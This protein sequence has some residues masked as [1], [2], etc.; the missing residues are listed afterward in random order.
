MRLFLLLIVFASVGVINMAHA[1]SP[2][3]TYQPAQNEPTEQ[4]LT[5]LIHYPDDIVD[6]IFQAS[7]YPEQVA[8][9]A[10]YLSEPSDLAGE[11]K[12][13][14]QV[15]ALMQ[16][17]T[18]LL[19]ISSDLVW[20][21]NLG[22]AVA[23]DEE[24]IWLNLAEQRQVLLASA[25]TITVERRD[26]HIVYRS[27]PKIRH[28]HRSLSRSWPHSSS[29]RTY[30]Y[31][32][33]PTYSAYWNRRAHRQKHWHNGHHH[34]PLRAHRQAH[35]R[36][37]WR[38]SFNPYSRNHHLFQPFGHNSHH[39][40]GYINNHRN[41]HRQRGRHHDAFVY[42]N[43]RQVKRQITR[44]RNKNHHPGQR[45]EGSK[46][47]NRQER[48]AG[49]QPSRSRSA[50]GAKPTAPSANR[51]RHNADRPNRDRPHRDRPH[52]DRPYMSGGLLLP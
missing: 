40:Y 28:A 24:T 50:E 43:Q 45:L 32:S 17:P 26:N 41:E 38:H 33:T 44:E 52:R 10:R 8:L 11:P 31:S 3:A 25:E 21:Q 14:A 15:L 37:R 6:I 5:S 46:Q 2:K 9:A 36:D 35:R 16:Y 34:K 47:T 1:G 29:T 27:G 4:L 39:R 18:L 22:R 20:L 30:L 23:K 13:N 12:F 42:R 49:N 51:D 19:Q 48:S 7:A